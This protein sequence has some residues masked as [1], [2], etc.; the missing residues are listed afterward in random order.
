M[1]VNPIADIVTGLAG[2]VVALI[3]ELH[4]SDEERLTLKQKFF[5]LQVNLYSKVLEYEGKVVDAQSR[6]VEAEAKS[7]SWLAA[8]WRPIMMVTFLCLVVNKW[9]GL[10]VIL[11]FPQIFIPQEIELELWSLMKIG[12]GGY[13][14]G[15]TLEKIAPSVAEA[16][17]NLRSKE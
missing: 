9:T 4:T 1:G 7:E 12:I 10:S 2:P 17:G 13:V 6:V 15:R 16:I 5:E 8:N 14:G 3:D 11:G